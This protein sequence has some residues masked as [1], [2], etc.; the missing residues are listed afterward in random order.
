MELSIIVQWTF[1]H[2]Y[3]IALRNLNK[4]AR[5]VSATHDHN[6]ALR[7][8]RGPVR[9]T[10]A[11]TVDLRMLESIRNCQ[12]AFTCHKDYCKS[13]LQ[14]RRVPSGHVIMELEC[15]HRL[16]QS[17]HAKL[18]QTLHQFPPV[19]FYSILRTSIHERKS[20]EARTAS[21]LSASSLMQKNSTTN[22][23]EEPA[24]GLTRS[25]QKSPRMEPSPIIALMQLSFTKPLS[26]SI[27]TKASIKDRD[28]NTLQ[29]QLVPRESSGPI[30]IMPHLEVEIVVLD[31]DFPGGV[32]ADWTSE[33][34][35]SHIVKERKGKRPLLVGDCKV[36]VL[37]GSPASVHKLEFTDNSSWVRS[38][39]FRLGARVISPE[40][41]RGP[42]R[43]KE[44]ITDRF[45]V[46][47]HRGEL[48]KKHHPPSL[49]D[50]VWRLKNI[51]KNGIFDKRLADAGIRTVQDLLKLS[52]LDMQRLR[53]Y[54]GSNDKPCKVLR[55]GE[56]GVFVPRL[57]QEAYSNWDKLEKVDETSLANA[58]T[59]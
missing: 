55:N 29:I 38:R 36:T 39:H 45:T 27:Y 48:N 1:D 17:L 28:N 8:R 9:Y 35:E 32:D 44:A 13:S 31:G 12:T 47:D 25:M 18:P 21:F 19:I 57:V 30:N 42:I 22:N 16:S 51:G 58:V 43:I 14:A 26:L 24:V 3:E 7:A 56:G 46:L 41:Y 11:V 34:F 52:M 37:Q 50:R 23:L 54:V 20:Q 40:S 4:I 49:D 59:L 5:R 6:H 10:Y 2:S 15:F 53:Q 33:D